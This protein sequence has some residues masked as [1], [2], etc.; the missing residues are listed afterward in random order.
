MTLNSPQARRIQSLAGVAC[1]ILFA[2][3]GSRENLRGAYISPAVAGQGDRISVYERRFDAAREVLSGLFGSDRGQVGYVSDL[4]PDSAAATEARYLA[5]YAMSPF[6]FA[7][8]QP[9]QTGL[10]DPLVRQEWR[11]QPGPGASPEWFIGNFGATQ[12]I[13]EVARQNGLAIARDFGEGVVLL[14]RAPQ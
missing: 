1:L 10:L 8:E 9:F 7:P 2:A 14:R 11:P 12:N 5:Q 3:Y 4:D 6:V 13:P